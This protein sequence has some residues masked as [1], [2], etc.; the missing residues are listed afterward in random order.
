MSLSPMSYMLTLR[1]GRVALSI[2]GVKGHK[3]VK[4]GRKRLQNVTGEARCDYVGA[5][6]ISL[7]KKL[8]TSDQVLLDI[9]TVAKLTNLGK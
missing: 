3:R 1:K 7:F 6:I 8:V 5:L 9:L 2:L 4:R